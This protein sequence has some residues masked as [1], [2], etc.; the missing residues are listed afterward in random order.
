MV[1]IM[2]QNQHIK[3]SLNIVIY[4]IVIFNTIM[5]GYCVNNQQM[6]S[7]AIITIMTLILILHQQGH[8][9]TRYLVLKYL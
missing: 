6:L 8:K 9:P 2:D 7:A 5:I 4:C 1:G 3:K